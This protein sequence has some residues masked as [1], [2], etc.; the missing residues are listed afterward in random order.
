MVWEAVELSPL[1]EV[2]QN[3][4]QNVRFF[5]FSFLSFARECREYKTTNASDHEEQAGKK[6]E[7]PLYKARD[8]QVKNQG[9][10]VV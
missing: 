7:T 1:S 5:S 10:K 3:P 6:T 4:W 9:T 2:A 8:R